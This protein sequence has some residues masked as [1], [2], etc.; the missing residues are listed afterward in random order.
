M[1]QTTLLP[2][3]ADCSAIF[4]ALRTLPD[5][6]WFD[7]GKPASGYGR[8]DI[9]T[10]AP[11]ELLSVEHPQADAFA[12][13]QTLLDK[14]PKPSVVT[15]GVPFVGGLAGYFSYDLGNHDLGACGEGIRSH[16]R[17]T[18]ILPLMRLGLYHWSLVSDHQQQSTQLSFLDSCPD[19]VRD[20]V[21]NIISGFQTGDVPT[22]RPF[23]LQQPFAASISTAD[24]HG[25]ISR[26]HDYI[27]AGDC[28][29]V[30]FAQ[31]FS[32]PFQGDSFGAYQQLRRT[33]P[34]PFSAYME[35]QN[36]TGNQAVLSLSPERLLRVNRNGQVQTKPIKGTIRRGTDR[37]SDLANADTLVN[38]AK[39]RAENLMIVDLLRNDLGKAC[40]PGSIEVPQLFALESF[41]NVHHLVSTVTG[42]LAADK[43]R[44]QLLQGCFPGGSITGAPKRRA[45]EI[46]DELETCQRSV[47]CGSLGY[48][49]R[50]G[51]MDFNIAIRTLVAD[52]QTLHC[53][54]G[55]G[56]VA[57]SSA[58][59]EYRES[60]DKVERLM[61]CLEQR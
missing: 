38:S 24:Y 43:T 34:S 56:I 23:H 44:L 57:D 6:I 10:A 17:S 55:G 26:I 7:S 19:D 9:I 40:Q 48:I 8:F 51:R 11:S 13:A 33:T 32:A 20:Q 25:A 5:A 18:A 14:L 2:Y 60:L 45:M 39:D 29:Q 53:W 58:S 27:L 49:S 59:A 46:I 12:Q 37:L 28:Y 47:Y 15:Q 42:Q 16:S 50:C 41:A 61:K 1:H 21:H 4:E 35:W 3:I 30:N 54:G 31:H 52:Q 36:D 22:A